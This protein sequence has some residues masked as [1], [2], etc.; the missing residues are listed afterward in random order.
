MNPANLPLPL[1]LTKP[2]LLAGD[3]ERTLPIAA[4]AADEWAPTAPL[5]VALNVLAL[6]L[7]Q[8]VAFRFDATG[9]PV[10][11]PSTRYAG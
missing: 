11:T 7:P 4:P 1:Q 10:T 9:R 5:P 3:Q 8:S 6:V 2:V